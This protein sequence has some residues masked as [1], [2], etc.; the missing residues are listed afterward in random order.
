MGYRLNIYKGNKHVLENTKLYGYCDE[1]KLKSYHY[2]IGIGKFS[3]EYEHFNYGHENSVELKG[4]QL[5]KFIKY[6]IRDLKKYYEYKEDYESEVKELQDFLKTY[7]T[8]EIYI[9]KWE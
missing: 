9:I 8:E 7:K 6:Y 5:K 3:G 1:N 4:I 2:L